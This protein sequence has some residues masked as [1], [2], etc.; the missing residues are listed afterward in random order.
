MYTGFYKLK[1]LPFQLGPDPRFFYGSSVHQK[2][3]AYVTYGLHQGE[4][5]IVI[6]GDIGAGKTTLVGHLL[7]TLDPAKYIAATLV[8]TQLGAD[9]TLR[10]VASAFGVPCEGAD[11]AVIL[12]RVEAFL[13]GTHHAGRRSL[14]V[15]DEVQNLSVRALEELRMLSN[16]QIHGKPLLQSF[17]LGQPQFRGTLAS[18]ALEQLRQRVTASYHLGPLNEEETRSYIE[19]RLKLVDWDNDP[20]FTAEAFARIYTLTGGVPRK[21]NTLASRLL[22]SGYLDERHEIEEAMVD[23]VADELG[24]EI[25]QVTTAGAAPVSF[26]YAPGS[27]GDHGASALAAASLASQGDLGFRVAVLEHQMRTHDKTIKRALEIAADY[28]TSARS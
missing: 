8:T 26:E 14:L 7:A 21:I 1:G 9:D 27:N 20:S 4:G 23:Q 15:V 28:L 2:A 13:A 22:L 19:H 18:P 16:F 25:A 5:F 10:M 11:K 12:R 3:M 6:T 17:L 24:A